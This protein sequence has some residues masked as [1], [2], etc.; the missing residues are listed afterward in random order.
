M[1]SPS[2][3][4]L[5]QVHRSEAGLLRNVSAMKEAFGAESMVRERPLGYWACDCIRLTRVACP[6]NREWDRM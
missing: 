3:P 5:G 6:D 1:Y 2:A 4:S